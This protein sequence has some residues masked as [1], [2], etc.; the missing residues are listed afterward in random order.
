M[1][2]R[3]LVSRVRSL[4]KLVS[5]DNEIT[6]RV[7]FNLLNSYAKILIKR[8]TNL[9]KLWNSPNIFTSLECVKMVEAPL[10]ECCDYKSPCTVSRSSVKIPLISEG[11]FG[12]L[13]QHVFSPGK[14]K[15]EYAS[16]DRYMN[17]LKLGLKN[18]SNLYWVYNDYLYTSDSNIEYVDISAHFESEVVPSKYSSCLK[19][20]KDE[21]CNVNPLDAIFKIPSY[22]EESL[23]ALVD[24][25]LSETYFRHI[26]DPQTNAKDESR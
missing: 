12:L 21:K 23:L 9:R 6:D 1:T 10:S 18:T 13:V 5:S 8:E 4:N 25:K 19:P 7:I 26:S 17:I 15:F 11:I 20:S 3:D 24:K 22:L 14:K 2:G 16:P